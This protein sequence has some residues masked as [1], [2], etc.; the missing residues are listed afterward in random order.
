MNDRQHVRNS[1]KVSSSIASIEFFHSNVRGK[2]LSSE[3][4]TET[5]SKKIPQGII[6]LGGQNF[7]VAPL[8]KLLTN[9]SF[10]QYSS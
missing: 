9:Y 5:T 8:Q 2:S 1:E 4:L 7:S 3:C 10:R 6:K